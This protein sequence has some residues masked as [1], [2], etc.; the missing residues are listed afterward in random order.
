MRVKDKVA[1]VTGAALGIGKGIAE[2]LAK[3]G[4]KVVLTD[5]NEEEGKAT[6]EAIVNEGGEAIFIKHDVAKEEEWKRVIEKTK[7]EYGT[8]DILVNNA[9]VYKA[10]SILE[11]TV[12]EWDFLMNVNVK[13]T[14]LGMK[15]VIPTMRER[16]SG[17][18]I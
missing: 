9:G 8:I 2:I 14:F 3:E 10:K 6:T 4:A 5:I 12:D 15:H 1:I 18:I 11:T 16:Q 13:G 7:E 17:S